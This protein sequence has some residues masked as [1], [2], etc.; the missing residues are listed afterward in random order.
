VGI[1]R[2]FQQAEIA[3]E[4]YETGKADLR[5]GRTGNS[6]SKTSFTEAGPVPIKLTKVRPERGKKGR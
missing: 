1:E 5:V 6:W 3:K 4:A 2:G